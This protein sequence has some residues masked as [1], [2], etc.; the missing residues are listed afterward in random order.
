MAA[1]TYQGQKIAI[2][3]EVRRCI[4][5]AEC[6]NRLNSVFDSTQKPWIQPDGAMADQIAQ[7]I[8]HCP[9]GSLTYTRSDGQ[10]EAIPSQNEVRVQAK[11]PLYL[12][13]DLHLH[14]PT[15]EVRPLTRLALCR[16]GKSQNKPF[17]D[18][19]HLDGFE[20][21]DRLGDNSMLNTPTEAT[22][23]TIQPSPNGSLKL[24][25][26]LTLHGADETHYEGTQVWLCR[27]GGSMN[28]PFCDGSHK[29]V[30]FQ[31]E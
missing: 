19:A 17:C 12:R 7:T 2:H 13:G 1:K 5:A 21:S 28:K 16:C 24:T 9:S 25:G 8:E 14:L 10:A 11:G 22:S 18:N 23:L 30:G 15:G 4:H 3:Y 6:V 29:D 20:A 27:C 26:H 31:A